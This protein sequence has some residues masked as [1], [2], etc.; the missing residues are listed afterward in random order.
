MG[1]YFLCTLKISWLPGITYWQ[2]R[3]T[4]N[5][6]NN[7]IMLVILLV[8]QNQGCTLAVLGGPWHFASI[9]VGHSCISM[10]LSRKW[11]FNIF[12]YVMFFFLFSPMASPDSACNVIEEKFITN[13]FILLLEL[14]QS[15][16]PELLGTEIEHF[17]VSVIVS[18]IHCYF[19]TLLVLDASESYVIKRLCSVL[20]KC[21]VV[22]WDQLTD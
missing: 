22:L 15:L 14:L 16:T 11:W 4:D 6:T 21:F 17:M 2:M 5:E 13:A 10:S 3:K 19:L 20:S 18:E 8:V 7:I 1:H 9:C 12:S